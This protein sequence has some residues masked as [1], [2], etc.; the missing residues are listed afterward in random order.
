M[1]KVLDPI[2]L[3]SVGV[4]IAEGMSWADKFNNGQRVVQLRICRHPPDEEC[5]DKCW[6]FGTGRILGCW[7]GPANTLPP[8]LLC[9]N[10]VGNTARADVYEALLRDMGNPDKL[11]VPPA[12]LAT[13]VIYERTT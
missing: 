11:T 10:R 8:N 2:A 12:T 5:A 4:H 13:A 9:L 7:A 3:N 1:L 6:D